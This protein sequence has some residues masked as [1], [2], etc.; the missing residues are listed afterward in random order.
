MGC[1][2][3]KGQSGSQ[4]GRLKD[5]RPF[6]KLFFQ[7]IYTKYFPDFQ[8]ICIG[9]AIFNVFSQC[10]YEFAKGFVQPSGMGVTGRDQRV[11]RV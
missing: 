1:P 5:A 11:T 8:R 3:A 6:F 2:L 10:S 7:S 9:T 4:P